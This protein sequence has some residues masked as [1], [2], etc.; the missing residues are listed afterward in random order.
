ML[1][2]KLLTK[3]ILLT[4]RYT[5]IL[6]FISKM[7]NKGDDIIKDILNLKEILDYLSISESMLRKLI[8]EKRIPHFRIGNRIKFNLN[9]INKWIEKNQE[10]ESQN[11]LFF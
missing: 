4:K 11:S 9:E 7:L 5:Y 2:N 10:K 8:R 1:I 3:I 6:L